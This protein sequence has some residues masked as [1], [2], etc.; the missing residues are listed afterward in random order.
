MSLQPE[1][2]DED[3]PEVLTAQPTS[4]VGLAMPL[5]SGG[6]A[7]RDK[8]V[9]ESHRVLELFV[10]FVYPLDLHERGY[11]GR[12][13]RKGDVALKQ[14]GSFQQLT[15]QHADSTGA[16]VFNLT[17]N[18]RFVRLCGS[19]RRELPGAE[20]TDLRESQMLPPLPT[21]T[22]FRFGTHAL[23]TVVLRMMSN[24]AFV[25]NRKQNLCHGSISIIV[26]T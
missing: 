7:G 19:R 11:C 2:F 10:T 3:T 6:R 4:A 13:I 25:T 22:S 1:L 26:S 5:G 15:G 24:A 18:D 23:S 8:K 20:L 14:I 16:D 17:A 9:P 12:E 21:P